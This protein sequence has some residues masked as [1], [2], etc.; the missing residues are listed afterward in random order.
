M[1]GGVRRQK[2]SRADLVSLPSGSLVCSSRLLSFWV[3]R[4]AAQ[5]LNSSSR[6]EGD[7]GAEGHD[8]GEG[9]G[10]LL[11]GESQAAA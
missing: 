3:R 11:D 9:P 7:E 8:G 10:A 2:E 4:N 6:M 5:E 1:L